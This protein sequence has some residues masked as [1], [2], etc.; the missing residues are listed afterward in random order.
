ML[1][2]A[3]SSKMRLCS[4]VIVSSAS[5]SAMLPHICT[6]TIAFVFELIAFFTDSGFIVRVS[7]TSTKTGVAPTL[8]TDSKL[9]TNVKEGMIT[10]SPAPI[11]NAAKAVVKAEVPLEVSCAYLAPNLL[12][13]AASSS[14][15]FQIP[16]RKLSKP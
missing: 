11:P 15:D 16:L 7:S 12:Q 2:Q 14:F 5:R 3:S 1:W 8:K 6:G 9:A 13:I 10:S 4:L